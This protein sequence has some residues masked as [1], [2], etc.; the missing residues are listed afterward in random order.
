MVHRVEWFWQN[1]DLSFCYSAYTELLAR[2]IRAE[3]LDADELRKH[4]NSDLGF[5]KEDRDENIRR[6]GFVANLL[7]QE[8]SRRI[9]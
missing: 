6:I 9:L 4:L 1:D 2:G 3:L 8:L 7:S 5:T